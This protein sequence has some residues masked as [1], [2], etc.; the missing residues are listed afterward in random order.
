MFIAASLAVVDNDFGVVKL[1]L[2]R[3]VPLVVLR[4]GVERSNDDLRAASAA[5]P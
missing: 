5:L 3:E 4:H 1:D 2:E